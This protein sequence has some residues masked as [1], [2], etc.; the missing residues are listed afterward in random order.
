MLEHRNL[1]SEENTRSLKLILLVVNDVKVGLFLARV[2]KREMMHHVIFASHEFQALKI[3]QEVKPDL[4]L[5]DYKLVSKGDFKLYD[6]LHATKG[7]EEVPAILSDISTRFSCHDLKQWCLGDEEK[8]SEL[9]DFLHLI[10]EI[11]T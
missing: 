10:Q 5:L 4:F 9:E 8:S 6:R 1:F 7:L 2:I 11:L 3:V